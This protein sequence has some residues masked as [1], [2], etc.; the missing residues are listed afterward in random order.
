MV[1]GVV[2][3][4]TQMMISQVPVSAE[5]GVQLRPLLDCQAGAVTSGVQGVVPARR[6]NNAYWVEDGT[7]PLAVAVQVIVLP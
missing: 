5:V 4:L 1:A 3:S 7:P 2:P 6:R